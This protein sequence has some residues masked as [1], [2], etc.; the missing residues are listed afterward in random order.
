MT[1]PSTDRRPAPPPIDPAALG[2][3]VVVAAH[4]DDGVLA[5]GGLLRAV[6]DTGG[7]VELVVATGAGPDGLDRAL[8][9]IGLGGVP[10]HR[11]GLGGDGLTAALVPLLRDADTYLAPWTGDPHPDQAA[12]GRA[13]ADAAPV[14]AFGFGY[15]AGTWERMAADDPG[16]PW[17]HAYTHPL[18]ADVRAAKRRARACLGAVAVREAGTEVVFRY[19]RSSGAPRARFDELYARGVGDPWE[20]RTAWYERR[21]RAMVLAC[22]PA[23]RYRH[24]A[25]PACGTGALT[26]D[27][28]A[29]CDRISASDF[30]DSAVAQTTAAVPGHV[31]VARLTLPDPAALPAG[32]DLAVLSEVLYY[33][34]DDDLA[35]VV[36]RLAAA[37]EL[38]GDVVLVHW[39]GWP[40]EAP[41]DGAAAHRVLLE[42][43]R[44]EL[45]VSVVDE[46]FLLHVLRRW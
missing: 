34:S 17:E 8:A 41:R 29:R 33:L 9:A 2:R 39:D 10:V 25:E 30:A 6:L 5:V 7:Q 13:A 45:L 15:P 42:D 27:L 36:D 40:A 23:E 21:K 12:T 3:V 19:P 46:E 32:I 44:F 37:L 18:D 26:G 22:L 28:A 31:D 16:V 11:L 35:A 14:T 4:P 20:T 38:G 24:A 1:S 43:P